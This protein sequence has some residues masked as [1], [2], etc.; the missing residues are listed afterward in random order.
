MFENIGTRVTLNGDDFAYCL[1]A[2]KAVVLLNEARSLNEN[3]KY[4]ESSR[5]YY[6]AEQLAGF[7][8]LHPMG[9]D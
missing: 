6:R 8:Y 2:E 1:E 4:T 5:A 9:G 3:R 7:R